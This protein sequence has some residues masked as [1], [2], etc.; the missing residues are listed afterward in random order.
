MA[1]TRD[2]TATFATAKAAR[3]LDKKMLSA[4]EIDF[5]GTSMSLAQNEVM[6]IVDIPAGCIIY[7]GFMKVETAEATITDVDIGVSTASATDA[8]LADGIS[9]ATTG[10]V[11]FN[12]VTA[13]GVK[14][15]AASELVLTNKDAQTL[16]AAKIE[17][18][19]DIAYFADAITS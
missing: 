13:G 1:L 18:I 11:A 5:S 15:T 3:G 4:F 12:N 17:V 6:G 16:D 14:T 19:I 2:L 10:Y 8:T 7:G 9:M